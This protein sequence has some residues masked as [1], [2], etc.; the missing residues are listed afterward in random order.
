MN[1]EKIFKNTILLYFLSTVV[2]LVISF[3]LEKNFLGE[4]LYLIDSEIDLFII[5]TLEESIFILIWFLVALIAFTI[6]ILSLYFLYYFK[7]IGKKLY[8][9]SLIVLFILF[10][11][12]KGDVISG[13]LQL[14]DY[15]GSLLEGIIICFLYFTPIKEKFN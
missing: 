7:P 5:P 15:F 11:F 14:M 10:I 12:D 6:N 3:T 8:I 1:L 2:F 4:E 9:Y 13:P